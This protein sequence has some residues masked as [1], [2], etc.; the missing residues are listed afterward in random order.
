[1]AGMAFQLLPKPTSFEVDQVAP[2]CEYEPDLYPRGLISRPRMD[3]VMWHTNWAGGEASIESQRRWALA[4]PG[5]NTYPHY[6]HDRGGRGRKIL[7]TNRRSIANSGVGSWWAAKGMPDASHRMI[8]FETADRGT[9]TDPAPTGSWFTPA[10]ALAV[11]RDTAYE[12]IVHDIPPVILPKPEG[13]GIA[14]HCIPFGYPCV[15]TAPG[16][17]CPGHRKYAQVGNVLAEEIRDH[18]IPWVAYLVSEWT[19]STPAPQPPTDL[20]LLSDTPEPTLRLG[21]IGDEVVLLQSHLSRWPGTGGKYLYSATIDGSFGPV[22][23]AGLMALQELLR[24]EADGVYGPVTARAFDNA[25]R[26]LAGIPTPTPPTTPTPL[27]EPRPEKTTSL[28]GNAIYTV[29]DRQ[30]AWSV[31][32]AVWGDGRLHEKLLL[33]SGHYGVAGAKVTVPKIVLN[34]AEHNI[35][36]IITTVLPGEGAAAVMRRIHAEGADASL[37]EGA[38]VDREKANFY[39]WNGGSGRTLHPG[40]T[41]CLPVTW[42]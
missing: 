15:T 19:G 18:M 28:I 10:Q 35:P 21:S 26:G 37:T 7:R 40:D 4:A 36:G 38:F 23:Q 30:W 32:E 2:G 16:K 24:V 12:C 6:L 17:L 34:G 3:G 14:G 39:E 8:A 13:R 9:N 42:G 27:P 1:M 5:K 22:T 41:V 31:A 25:R 29:R 11:V 33:T 20:G